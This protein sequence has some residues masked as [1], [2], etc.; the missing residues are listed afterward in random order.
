ML[1]SE[2]LQFFLFA[3]DTNIYYEAESPEK[4]ELVINKE[5]KKLQTW[6]VV[7]RLTLN[8]DKTN[9]IVFHPYNKP[10]KHKITLKFQKKAILEKTILNI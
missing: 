1:I 2:V 4:L 3:D 8:I 7:N 9:F 10:M 6:L 5:L